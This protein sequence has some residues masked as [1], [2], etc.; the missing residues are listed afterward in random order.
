GWIQVRPN[1]SSGSVLKNGEP[2]ASGWTAEQTS[3]TKPCR[4]SSAE[5]APPPMVALASSTHTEHPACASVIAAAR[6]FGPDP[7]TTASCSTAILKTRQR[8]DW[9][10]G[11]TAIMP[12]R[13][14]LRPLDVLGFY[15][16]THRH[17]STSVAR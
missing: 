17:H 14:A 8:A 12:K 13:G 15:Y 9:F 1:R 5:R 6:P 7:T 4:V 10:R 11:W 2:A 16:E 3:C